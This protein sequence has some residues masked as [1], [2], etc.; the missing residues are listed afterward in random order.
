MQQQ[1]LFVKK[2]IKSAITN[3]FFIFQDPL[4][5]IPF[6]SLLSSISKDLISTANLQDPLTVLI[7]GLLYRQTSVKTINWCSKTVMLREFVLIGVPNIC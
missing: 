6:E 7:K 5:L 2:L 4:E 3:V 1:T